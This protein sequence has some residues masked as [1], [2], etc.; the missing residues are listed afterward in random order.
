MR[1][2]RA[3]LPMRDASI[4]SPGLVA[5][6]TWLTAATLGA[7]AVVAVELHPD[8]SGTQLRFTYGFPD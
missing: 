8:G 3:F 6:T 5:Q 2:D 1:G 7:E 4:A